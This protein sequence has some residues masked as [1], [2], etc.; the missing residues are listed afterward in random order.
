MTLIESLILG[1]I[2]GITEFFPISSSAH[3]ILLRP[4]LG[5]GDPDLWFDVWLHGGTWLAVTI[6]LIPRFRLLFQKPLL[7]VWVL[8]ATIPAGVIGILFEGVMED[9]LRTDYFLIG[10]ILLSVGIVFLFVRQRGDISLEKLG[11]REAVI[12][13]CAQALALVPGVSRSG[14]TLL[15]ALGVG[16]LR[17][18]AVI[19]SYFLS[20]TTIGGAFFKGLLEL[21]GDIPAADILWPG[22]IVS[23]VSGFFA[24]VYLLRIV[25]SKNLH[26][27]GIYR[28]IFAASVMVFL[29]IR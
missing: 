12:I 15:A 21:G 3:L 11:L 13:G 23:F 25:Q 19:F 1:L 18:D 5:F 2:Q 7:L 28:I 14:I 9:I 16:M 8:L 20:V 17:K 26:P 6:Y 10:S 29:L 4:V 27:F 24:C 22:F